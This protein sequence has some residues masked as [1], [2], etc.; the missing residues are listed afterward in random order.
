MFI[1]DRPPHGKCD[2]SVCRSC[3]RKLT[4]AEYA[5]GECKQCQKSRQRHRRKREHQQERRRRQR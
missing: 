1:F 2:V 4:S 5:Q 3:A